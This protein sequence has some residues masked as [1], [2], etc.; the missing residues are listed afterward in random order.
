MTD[1]LWERQARAMA[2]SAPD[3]NPEL[4]ADDEPFAWVTVP[5]AM[6]VVD[7]P[8]LLK[9]QDKAGVLIVSIAADGQVTFGPAADELDAASRAFWQA[10]GQA[11]LPWDRIAA[12]ERVVAI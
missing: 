5:S 11:A 7:V 10:F 3:A 4:T 8:P 2:A 9:F 1:A 6:V 12:L